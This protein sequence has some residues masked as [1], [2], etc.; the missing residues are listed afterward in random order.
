[1]RLIHF[2]FIAFILNSG[3]SI[4]QLPSSVL[5]LDGM[6]MYKEGSGYEVW[7]VEADQMDG[8]TFRIT[9]TG[10]TVLVEEMVIKS[11]NRRLTFDLKTRTNVNNQVINKTRSFIGGKRKMEF[12]NL[13]KSAPYSMEYKYGFFN[14]NKLRIHVRYSSKDDPMKYT[15]FKVKE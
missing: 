13:D 12:I 6:W 10:D 14:R 2:I 15:L 3:I 9:K 1:M 4:A 8:H 11:I 7:K 5:K